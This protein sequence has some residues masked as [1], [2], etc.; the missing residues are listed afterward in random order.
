MVCFFFQSMGWFP[1]TPDR[2][3]SVRSIIC[4]LTLSPHPCIL[5]KVTHDPLSWSVNRIVSAPDSSSKFVTVGSEHLCKYFFTAPT[6]CPHLLPPCSATDVLSNSGKTLS[7][8]GH[9]KLIKLCNLSS[10]VVCSG[11]LSH[12]YYVA[13]PSSHGP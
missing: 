13:R 7:K 6:P 4:P 10:G 1:F 9:E 5:V 12:Q 2:L 3:Y 8:I 11:A